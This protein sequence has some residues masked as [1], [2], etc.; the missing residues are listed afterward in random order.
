M[1]GTSLSEKVVSRN[2]KSDW[3]P[4][5]FDDKTAN[6]VLW[7]S[8]GGSKVCRRTQEICPVLDRP[9]RY[10]FSPQVLCKEGI[11]NMRAYW[12]VEYSGWVFIGVTYEGAPRRAD[13]EPSGLGENDESWG[14]CWAGS[15]YEVWANGVSEVIKNVPSCPVIGV[16]V[17]QPAGVICFY[18]VSGEGE[19]KQATLLYRFQTPIEKKVLPGFWMGIQSECKLL[20]NL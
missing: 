10:E 19:D 14:L 4:L 20:K 7:I 9:E 3:I 13:S 18:M 16:Y 6:R 8:D 5:T 1:P 17:D 11:W 15:C 12:E 2:G